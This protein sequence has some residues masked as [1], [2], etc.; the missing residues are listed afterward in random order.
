[1]SVKYDVYSL[2][3]II[4]ELVTGD[5]RIPDI[6]N[7]LRR[8]RHRLHKSGKETPLKY[9]QID[10]LIKIGLLCQEKDP[11]KRPSISDIIHVINEL[12]SADRKISNAN[13]STIGR[14]SPYSE[15][16]MLGVEPLELRFP[17]EL[18]N[19]ISCSLE[20]TNETNAFIA[21]N[22]QTTSPLPYCIQPNKDIVA[23]QSKY[24]VN[25]ALTR[26]HK[27]SILVILSSGAPK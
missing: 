27:I 2:G 25:I 11:C 15:D 23:P 8:W 1:M 10:K 3:I 16:D 21:F 18:N 7:V 20:L 22:I 6:K 24:S 12:E 9:Q 13:E 19:Q 4:I 14:M 5:R 26:H 17:F